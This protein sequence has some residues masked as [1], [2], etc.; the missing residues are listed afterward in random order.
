MRTRKQIQNDDTGVAL[1][2]SETLPD[3]RAPGDLPDQRLSAERN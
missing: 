1:A 3:L 2:K